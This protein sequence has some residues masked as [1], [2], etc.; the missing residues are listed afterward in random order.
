QDGIENLCGVG[1]ISD[2]PSNIL[3]GVFITCQNIKNSWIKDVLMSGWGNALSINDK[4]C[5]VQDC[6]YTNPATGTASAAPAAF[7]FG[8]SAA[9]S[10][11][12]RCASDGGYYHIMVTQAATPGPNVFLNFNCSG[13]HY[14]GGPHQR[15]A[16]GA[17]HDNIHMAPDSEGD[18][19]PY[20]AI[21]NRGND[22]SGQGWSAGFSVM[23]NCVVPQFQFEQPETTTN[24]YNWTIGG[25]GATAGYSDNGIY[26]T[27]GSI[28]TPRSLYLEQL[29]ERLGPLALENIG[30]APFALSVAPL[31]QSVAG[32]NNASFT[33]N[34]SATNYFDDT[35][36]LSVSGLPPNAGFAFIT[37]S[38]SGSGSTIL[39]VTASNSITP[40][41]YTLSINALDGN[42][43]LSTNVA[44]AVTVPAAPVFGTV[45]FNGN[46]LV[47][48]GSNGSPGASYYVLTTTNLALPITNW[49]VLATNLFGPSGNFTF[50]NTAPAA[51]GQYFLLRSGEN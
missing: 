34:V 40:G 15:W 39:T 25:T 29:K 36:A 12:Q 20:L 3:N 10:L 35:V 22:G 23:Y 28:V 14:N 26:D 6:L 31:T 4:W 48:A 19:T 45:E 46:A 8:G 49:T 51:P 11:F 24:Q 9:Q 41:Q 30:Y 38:I 50:T 42:L 7:T 33:L 32:G 27:L 37:N 44:L 1:Q 17:L 43:T 5:T 21:N 13:T 2:Y 16:A 47:I 18:Y